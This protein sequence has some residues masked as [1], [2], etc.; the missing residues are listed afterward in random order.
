MLPVPWLSPML[1]DGSAVYS[2]CPYLIA[3]VRIGHGPRLMW[4]RAR[5]M[6]FS[7]GRLTVIDAR[8]SAACTV[9]WVPGRESGRALAASIA[10]RL[11][12][13]PFRRVSAS[14]SAAAPIFA[15]TT[16]DDEPARRLEVREPDGG[17]RFGATIGSVEALSDTMSYSLFASRTDSL[18]ASATEIRAVLR[19]LVE[20]GTVFAAGRA[21]TARPRRFRDAL[22]PR[23]SDVDHR[24]RGPEWCGVR[25]RVHRCRRRV[26][27]DAGR[28]SEATTRA[29][30]RARPGRRCVVQPSIGRRGRR[31][32]TV[33][34]H[35]PQR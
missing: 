15:E 20:L 26:P 19:M 11:L 31:P 5:P 22:G 18:F 7:A 6:F 27:L 16:A 34:R 13:A 2:F 32:T 3:D 9:A 23:R 14:L 21:E 25:Q 29:G 24:I 1:V 17:L 33:S 30:G 4:S 8:D 12:G 35:P 28:Y 10:T